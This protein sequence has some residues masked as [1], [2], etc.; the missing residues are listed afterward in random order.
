MTTERVRARIA[1]DYT[2][3]DETVAR[4]LIEQ[5]SSKLAIWKEVSNGDRVELAALA[6]ARGDTSRLNDAMDLALRDWRDLLV[7]V[8]DA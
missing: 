7:A 4:E 2:G 1:R 6:F 5:L 3:A 8:G